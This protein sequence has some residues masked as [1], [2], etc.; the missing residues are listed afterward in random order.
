MNKLLKQVEQIV[1]QA[2]Q[3]KEES[4]KRGEQFNMFWACKVNHYETSHSAIIAELLNPKGLHGQG[5]LF[6]T[7]FLMSYKSDFCF[8]LEKGATVATEVVTGDGRIDILITNPEGQAIIIENK[9]Y[10]KDQWEQLKRYDK[11]ADK[12]F[13]KGNYKI[14][15]LTLFG[16]EASDQSCKDVEYIPISYEVQIVEWLEECIGFSARLPLIRETL[17]QYQ[18][19]IKLLTNQT[20]ERV[21]QEKLFEAMESHAEEIEAIVNAANKGYLRFIWRKYVKPKFEDYAAKNGL[22]YV[23]GD[24]YQYFH[25]PEWKR[26]AVAIC[27]G[28]KRHYIGVSCTSDSSLEYLAKLPKQRL[29]CL[30]DE[31][32]DWWPYGTEWLVPYECWDAG[33]GTI[34]AMKDG[35]FAKF[36]MDKV[37]KIIDEIEEKN[38]LMF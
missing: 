1:S 15:Y 30:P 29:S 12:K 2:K 22:L 36:V 34:P 31:P 7:L 35:R 18:Q 9:I 14:L 16:D 19:H 37:K 28:G 33:N 20:M 11:Y 38:L 21:E 6:L 17:I 27:A 32:T 3:A 10:A 24:T 8:S 25:R 5:E 26:A 23:D 4:R 13:G